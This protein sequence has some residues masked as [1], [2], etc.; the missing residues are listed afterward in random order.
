MAFDLHLYLDEEDFAILE[1]LQSYYRK[2]TGKR[3]NKQMILRIAL[4]LLYSKRFKQNPKP[5]NNF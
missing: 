1:D 5:K 4:R 2:K 3:I